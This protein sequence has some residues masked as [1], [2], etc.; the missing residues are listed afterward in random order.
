MGVFKLKN[1]MFLNYLYKVIKHKYIM[2]ELCWKAGIPLRGIMHDM[3]KFSPVELRE[4]WQYADGEKSLRE[5]C[6]DVKGFSEAWLHHKGHNPHHPEYWIDNLNG[7]P[8]PQIMDRDSAKEMICDWI[9]AGMAYDK[10]WDYNSPLEWYEQKG[11]YRLIHPEIKEFCFVVLTCIKLEQ[12]LHILTDL[13]YFYDRYVLNRFAKK[14][15]EEK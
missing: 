6:M 8:T 2:L 13:D 4:A 15:E 10:Y 5:N 14:D 12:S 1:K 9:A 11:Q 3:S 7:T